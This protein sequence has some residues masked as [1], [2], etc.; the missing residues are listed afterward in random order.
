MKYGW[1]F[2]KWYFKYH[3]MSL[4]MLAPAYALNLS[5]VFFLVNNLNMVH[6]WVFPA[7]TIGDL[8]AWFINVQLGVYLQIHWKWLRRLQK[9]SEVVLTR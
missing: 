3:M 5:I 6:L 7:V 2:L 8:I 1:R 9:E 4:L